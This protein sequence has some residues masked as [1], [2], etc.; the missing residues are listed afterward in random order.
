MGSEVG[1]RGREVRICDRCR[2]WAWVTLVYNELMQALNFAF[3]DLMCV[4]TVIVF[5]YENQTLTC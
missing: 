4:N 1:V 5:D 2:S 3:V